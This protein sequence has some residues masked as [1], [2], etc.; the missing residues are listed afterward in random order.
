MLAH[1]L[2]RRSVARNCITVFLFFTGALAQAQ[3]DIFQPSPGGAGGLVGEQLIRYNQ[4]SALDHEV[5]GVEVIELGDLAT[6]Q[7]NGLIKVTLPDAGCDPIIYKVK[8]VAYDSPSKYSWYGEVDHSDTTEWRDGNLMLIADNGVKFGYMTVEDR[9]Y[10]IEDL[11]GGKQ[12][13]IQRENTEGVACEVGSESL[14][15]EEPG[16]E[17]V[18]VAQDRTENCDIRIL[19]LYTDAALER[20]PGV[21]N[22]ATTAI[23]QTKQAFLNSGINTSSVNLITAG[24]ENFPNFMEDGK[25]FEDVLEEIDGHS[26]VTSRRNALGADL[27]ALL[28][29]KNVMAANDP[30]IGLAYVGAGGP[31]AGFSVVNAF[32]AHGR[33]FPFVHEIGHNLGA[34]HETCDAEDAGPVNS[35]NDDPGYAHAHTWSY[36]KMCGCG[37]FWLETRTV[38]RRTVMYSMGGGSSDVIQHFSN[39]F[40][41]YEGKSTGIVDE[42]HNALTIADNACTVANYR[43][44]NEAPLSATIY[45]FHEVCEGISAEWYTAS[46]SG[47]PGPYTYAWQVA[48][49]GSGG[50]SFGPVLSTN[51]FFELDLSG[52]VAGQYATIKLTVTKGSQSVT[53]YLTVHIIEPNDIR[54]FRSDKTENDVKQQLAD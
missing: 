24:I 48:V 53:N 12:A 38:R 11:T 5:A 33:G 49:S 19:V 10:S 16:V 40:V 27:V 54:C 46:V 1:L 26:F 17:A 22:I 8:N 45:G 7:D 3:S 31:W 23:T 34:R 20:F 32:G 43:T 4:F 37:W 21:A 51:S 47:P 42:R 52:M 44:T 18:P 36:K 25:T 30:P 2:L 29:D 50:M 13:L 14:K 41:K 15:P 39:P 28:V 6:L 9:F 35:C